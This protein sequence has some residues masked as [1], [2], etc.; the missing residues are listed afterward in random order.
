MSN[1]SSTYKKAGLLV[2]LA[3]L[4]AYFS[5][6]IAGLVNPAI[7]SLA[8]AY[9]ESSLNTIML[10]STLPMLFA[11]PTNFLSGPIVKKIG[12]KATLILG[13][14][15][16]IVSSVVPFTMRTSF[17]PILVTRAINGLGYGLISPITPMLVN[18]YIEPERRSSIL[19][20][21]QSVTQ[22]FGI[23]LSSVV[24]LVAARTVYNIWLINLVM[25]IPL[26][27]GLTLPKPPKF[28]E[29]A[30]AAAEEAAAQ[31]APVQKEKIP[32][33]AWVAIILGFV[34]F[35]FSYPAFLYLSP[36]IL[37]KGLGDAAMAGFVQT[38]FNVG[39][40]IAG[41]I[42]GRVL[43]AAKKRVIS[44]GLLLLVINYLLFAFTESVPLYYAA[45]LIGGIGYSIVYVGF[46]TI[47]SMNTAP[48]VF[49][50][51]MGIMSALMNCGA[52]ASSYV[53][54]FIAGAAGQSASLTFPFVLCAGV[55]VV[56]AVVLLIKPLK[57]PM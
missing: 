56:L 31:A 20:Y 57:M 15:I 22:G 11:I 24:G 35:V 26:I 9:P 48:T 34:W 4:T 19:G 27:L 13:L 8:A 40:V 53:I 55:F 3:V 28:E 39:G 21:G 43:A 23:V 51:A 32:V 14:A 5:N 50:T 52:F 54:T 6:A 38:M 1:S 49:P 46:I 44:V 36:L 16:F 42:F 41:L 12:V 2:I 10:V 25:C 18:A 33:V 45:N 29:A 7:A 30:A 47:L 37:G 17:T